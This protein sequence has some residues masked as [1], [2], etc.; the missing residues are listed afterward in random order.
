MCCL[1][2]RSAPRSACAACTASHTPRCAFLCRYTT[3]D[4]EYKRHQQHVA[5]IPK[6][7]SLYS[8]GHDTDREPGIGGVRLRLQSKA[9]TVKKVQAHHAQNYCI[10]RNLRQL[11]RAWTYINGWALAPPYL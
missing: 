7:A 9:C 8:V 1:R 5:Y 6:H 10:Q 4:A 2:A 11:H 3:G